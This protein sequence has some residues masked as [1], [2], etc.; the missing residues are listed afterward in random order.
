LV[1]DGP[2]VLE[3]VMVLTLFIHRT[4]ILGA[5]VFFV[6]HNVE[7]YCTEDQFSTMVAPAGQTCGGE[8]KKA[9]VAF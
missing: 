8:R 9:P 6:N 1:S 5:E 7:I 3:G 4:Y 2:I